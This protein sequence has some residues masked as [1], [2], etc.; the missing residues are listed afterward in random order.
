MIAAEPQPIEVR[1]TRVQPAA[2][3]EANPL[4]AVI[5]EEVGGTRR[6]RVVMRKAEADS[7]TAHLQNMQTERPM[8]YTFLAAVI[9]ALG[10][11]L[12]E[13]RIAGTD[14]RTIYARAVLTGGQGLQTVDA[15]P[16]DVIN[17]AL[18]IGAPILVEPAVFDASPPPDPEDGSSNVNWA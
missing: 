14:R 12:V 4:F 17:L 16:S 6:M 2:G 13:A 3:E 8:T 18:R 11:R 7:I 9:Q 1:V 10:G 5:L 15:R